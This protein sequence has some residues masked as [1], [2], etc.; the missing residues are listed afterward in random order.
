MNLLVSEISEE[1]GGPTFR[2]F[3][4]AA[5]GIPLLIGTFV[6]VLWLSPALLPDR[7]PAGVPTDEGGSGDGVRESADGGAEVRTKV[8]RPRLGVPA[9]SALV[10]VAL[11]VVGLVAGVAP[12]A[13]V[14]LCAALAMMILRVVTPSQAHRS[15]PITT[16]VTIAGM[17]PLSV[18]IQTSGAGDLIAGVLTSFLGD[19]HPRVMLLGLVLVVLALGQ[20]TSNVATVL[21]VAPIA[22]SVAEAG[23]YSVAPF[24]MGLCVAGA[25]ALFTPIATPAN[26]MIMAPGGYRFSDY[27]RMGL[28]LSALYVLVAVLWVPVVW[29]F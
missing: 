2:F 25:A 3:E 16:L 21:I 8:A 19:A 15:L 13:F 26:L 17:I 1:A 24:M 12:P 23:G 6:L 9:V 28:P 20:F 14:A 22:L 4:F 7:N 11:M 29:P 18:A 5:A 10:I 27:W